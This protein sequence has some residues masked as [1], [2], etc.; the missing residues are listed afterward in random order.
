MDLYIFSP[1]SSELQCC[2]MVCTLV[3]VIGTFPYDLYDVTTS[4]SPDQH[5]SWSFL[6]GGCMTFRQFLR[7]G[8]ATIFAYVSLVVLSVEDEKKLV[9]T[10]GERFCG[11]VFP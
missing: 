8:T 9:D 6:W 4:W 11:S 10:L 1:K 3:I 5:R 7:L 2:R